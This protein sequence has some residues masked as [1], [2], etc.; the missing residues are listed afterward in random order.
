MPHDDGDHEPARRPERLVRLISDGGGLVQPLAHL[1]SHGRGRRPRLFEGRTS[2]LG[3]AGLESLEYLGFQ[4]DGAIVEGD[5]ALLHAAHHGAAL[6]D[7]LFEQGT[8]LAPADLSPLEG[9]NTKAD[10]DVHDVSDPAAD[11][12]G[13]AVDVRHGSSVGGGRPLAAQ[14]PE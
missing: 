14:R 2:R 10:A 11:V 13:D 5:E 4:G 8:Q 1:G 9:E 12:V 3:Q 7:T 6:A